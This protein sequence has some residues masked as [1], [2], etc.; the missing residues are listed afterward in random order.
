MTAPNSEGVVRALAT[1]TDFIGMLVAINAAGDMYQYPTITYK[2]A[3]QSQ[4]MHK[5][6]QRRCKIEHA[7]FAFQFV[8]TATGFSNS[9]VFA[10]FLVRFCEHTKYVH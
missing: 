1:C 3:D 4:V 10:Q 8:N 2:A 9:T 7:P 6:F 5:N